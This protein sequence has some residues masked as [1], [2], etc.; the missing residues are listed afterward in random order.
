MNKTK[1]A[2]AVGLSILA[3]MTNS[4]SVF[5]AE[6]DNKT[7]TLTYQVDS[8]YDWIIHSAIDFGADAGPNKTVDR[9]GNQ[10]KVLKNV[11]PEGKYLN[12]SVKGDGTDG[13]FAL[14]NGKTE[15]LP[16]DVTDDAGAVAVNG[17]VLS[18][19]SGTNT[20]VQNMNFKLNTKK[21][22]AEIAGDYNGHVIYNA[23]LGSKNGVN[24][25]ETSSMLINGS[26]F[27]NKIPSEATTVIFTDEKAPKGIT[28]TDLTAKQ[29]G[30]VIG[31]LD[32]TTWKVSTQ[33]TKKK[34]LFNKNS[35]EM[36]SGKNY[37]QEI[38]FDNVDTSKVQHM[39]SVFED[40]SNLT[41][42][43][44]SNFNTSN[45]ISMGSMFWKCSKLMSLDLSSFDTSK[46]ES[47][48]YMFLGCKNLQKLDLNNFDTS[49]VEYMGAMFN[50]CSN[51][52]NLNISSFDTSQVRHMNYMFGGTKLSSLDLRHFNT[53]NVTTMEGM[54]NSCSNLANL[55][56]SSF[57][58]SN[59]ENMQF[60]F[61]NCSNL[62]NLNISSFDTSKVKYMG[63]MFED[64]LNL[65]ALDL[66]SLDTSNVT[67]MPY[68]FGNCSML[69][70]LDLS[71]FDTSNV[72]SVGSMF[73]GCR[74]L[75]KLDLSNFDTSKVE[76]MVYM[77][78][79]CSNLKV[80][81]A[82]SQ[83]DINNFKTKYT[84]VNSSVK[85]EIA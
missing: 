69:T 84:Y 61:K 51:L 12:I 31:W 70:S 68:M 8:N 62:T 59:V 24:Q 75:K 85:F 20:A 49:K 82:R 6:P 73:D 5:A 7:T 72:T 60:M 47:M 79:D 54:F 1:K 38:H 40:C 57:D 22:T 14:M 10:V 42:L 45:V 41:A 77:F 71:S 74:N 21:A 44:L 39:Q 55:N 30:D 53:S 29:D 26:A 83:T 28:T 3:M 58:T 2:M 56:I 78:K 63:Y 11:I 27:N 15:K 35:T 81:K 66:S 4:L 23:E 18:V 76:D 36:F 52:A 17:N 34:A 67:S 9:T 46:V 32:G 48:S 16:Y 19:P 65:T 37:L 43:D 13:T 64:C 33:D 80:I 25:K 50:S